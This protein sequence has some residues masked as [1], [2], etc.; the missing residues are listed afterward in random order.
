MKPVRGFSLVEL[1]VVITIIG[2]LAAIAIPNMTKMRDKAKETEVKANLHVIQVAIE[3]YAT[4]QHQYPAYLLGGS[5]TSWPI[6]AA[7]G[8]NANIKDPLIEYAY[9]SSYPDNPF[10]DHNVGGFYLAQTG[11]NE[12]TPASGDPRFGLKGS[13]MPNSVDDPAY[14]TTTPGNFSETVNQTA[15]VPL[16]VNYGNFGGMILG[17]G[18]PSIYI[19]PGSFLYRAVGPVDM[20]LS[21]LA[22]GNPTKKDFVYTRI[23][24]Y[25]LAGFGSDQTKGMDY[26]RLTGQ[27]VY[28]SQPGT[29]FPFPVPL[30]LPEVFGGGDHDNNPYFPYEPTQ[31]GVP[32]TYGA[33][34]GLEDGIIL[35]LTDSGEN[36][37]M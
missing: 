13:T 6:F 34:D 27:G 31:D 7:R 16:L 35:V 25:I 30:A 20:S 18:Q 28:K 19:I 3:R 37:E 15:G 9:I 26:I 33:P 17:S 23:E 1:L 4:D 10:V 5:Q 24:R 22:S 14:F 2:I 32:F 36:K 8:V 29:T 21:N 12:N 11:G